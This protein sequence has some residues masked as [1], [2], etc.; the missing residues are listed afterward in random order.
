MDVCVRLPVA[1]D[2]AEGAPVEP[3]STMVQPEK[4]PEEK[5]SVSKGVPGGGGGGGGVPVVGVI[6]FSIEGALSFPD[7]SNAVKIN[8]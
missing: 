4:V 3:S 2:Q 5:S 1:A 8:P 6:C 7:V